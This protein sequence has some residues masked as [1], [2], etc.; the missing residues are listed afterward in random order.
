MNVWRNTAKG[1]HPAVT[2][3][4]RAADGAS[5]EGDRLAP[6]VQGGSAARTLPRIAAGRAPRAPFRAWHRTAIMPGDRTAHRRAPVEVDQVY[7]PR[8]HLKVVIPNRPHFPRP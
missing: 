5:A 6:D 2:A 8:R 1:V 7:V 4:S 3:P